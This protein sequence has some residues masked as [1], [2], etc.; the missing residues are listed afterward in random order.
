[1]NELLDYFAELAEE[2]GMDSVAEE[3]RESCPRYVIDQRAGC[4]AVV[5]TH[6]PRYP[7]GQ[8]LHRDYPEVVKFWVGRKCKKADGY[9]FHA[10]Y[11]TGGA[12]TAAR[13]LARKLNGVD[14]ALAKASAL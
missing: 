2:A 13:R 5:D 3:L 11:V 14:A 8:G 1:M 10:W 7:S 9:G 4:I 12:V 6:H